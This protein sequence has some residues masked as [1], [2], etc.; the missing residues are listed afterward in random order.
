VTD[1][2]R[3]SRGFLV[4]A[5]WLVLIVIVAVTG[6]WLAAFGLLGL[7]LFTLVAIGAITTFLLTEA[8]APRESL[9]AGEPADVLTVSS[10]IE[11]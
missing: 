8:A 7:A 11:V 5:A 4:A 1:V 6:T 2:R 10:S 3:R 9:S